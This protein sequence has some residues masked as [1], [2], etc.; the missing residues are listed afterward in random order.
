[1]A[2]SKGFM[3]RFW[4]WI[5]EQIVQ[6]VPEDI[7]ACEF[8][9]RCVSEC[10]KNQCPPGDS[11]VHQR[12]LHGVVCYVSSAISASE[13]ELPKRQFDTEEAHGAS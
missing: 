11:R 3:N 1:M 7:A 5:K 12:H 2:S 9:C 8:D 4:S 6:E 10:R 13:A